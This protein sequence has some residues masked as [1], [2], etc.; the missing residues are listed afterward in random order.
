MFPI[1]SKEKE[2]RFIWH[3]LRAE[4]KLFVNDAAIDAGNN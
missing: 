2:R 1:L 3:T 4:D